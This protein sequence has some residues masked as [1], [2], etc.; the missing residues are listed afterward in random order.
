[1][2]ALLYAL[3]RAPL[4]T[5]RRARLRRLPA[6]ER[7]ATLRRLRSTPL[8]GALEALQSI[9]QLAYYGDDAVMRSLGF[10][11]SAVVARCRELRAAE[12]RW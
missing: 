8:G 12:G 1:M 2:R 6:D 4:V 7:A 3:E 5:G 11:A 9:V 10:D